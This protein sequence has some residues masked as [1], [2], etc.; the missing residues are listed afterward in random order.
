[1]SE[2]IKANG[3]TNET[4]E[5]DA[6]LDVIE[7]DAASEDQIKVLEES[8]PKAKTSDYYLFLAHQ[9]DI[10]RQRS[11]AFNASCMRRVALACRARAGFAGGVAHQWLRVLRFRSCAAFR[12]AGQAQRYGAPG[13]RY[14]LW[15]RCGCAR[16]GGQVLG[17]ADRGAGEIGADQIKALYE[18]GLNELEVLDLITR[19]PSLPG[20]IV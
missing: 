1:M 13:V 5:W 15:C 2:I 19:W 7:L 9:P 6:W 3:F 8:H 17:G 20:P 4:L 14:A 16:A 11:A 12:A 10:L 18:V